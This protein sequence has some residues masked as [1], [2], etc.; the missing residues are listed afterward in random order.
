MCDFC[1]LEGI[2]ISPVR[3]YLYLKVLYPLNSPHHFHHFHHGSTSHEGPTQLM[4]AEYLIPFI[5]TY[6]LHCSLVFPLLNLETAERQSIN[7]VSL[8]E[9]CNKTRPDLLTG[10]LSSLDNWYHFSR[11]SERANEQFS[12]QV[13]Y[14]RRLCRKGVKRAPFPRLQTRHRRDGENRYGKS[15]PG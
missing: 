7:A 13:Q 14:F 3:R 2:S 5:F 4:C 9:G 12:P 10:F 8:L 6:I 1:Q 15:L 11:E